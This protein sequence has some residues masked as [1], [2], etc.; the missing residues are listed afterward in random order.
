MAHHG[1][2]PEIGDEKTFH[3]IFKK[4][5]LFFFY[6]RSTVTVYFIIYLFCNIVLKYSL[7]TKAIYLPFFVFAGV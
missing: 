1:E 3:L 7:E 5:N 6:W 4:K 2:Q